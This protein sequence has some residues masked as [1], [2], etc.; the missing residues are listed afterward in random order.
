M[1]DYKDVGDIGL[2]D[3]IF[4]IK[5]I[6]SSKRGGDFLWSEG[7]ERYYEVLKGKEYPNLGEYSSLI[8]CIEIDKGKRAVG[9]IN[10]F[11]NA[12][13]ILNKDIHV[14]DSIIIEKG[15]VK[16]QEPYEGGFDDFKGFDYLILPAS[17]IRIQN[18]IRCKVIETQHFRSADFGKA[19]RDYVRSQF[20]VR[21]SED[22]DYWK[23]YLRKVADGNK[24]WG[25]LLGTYY[26]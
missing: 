22:P 19:D 25:D 9:L 5:A 3:K 15:Y 16:I 4:E 24:Y 10:S 23:E 21:I 11:R 12:Q 18:I 8:E 1:A 6:L 14:G 17:N 2:K 7:L 26:G 20:K 13:E